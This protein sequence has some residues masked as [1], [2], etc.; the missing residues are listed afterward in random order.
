[1]FAELSITSNFTFLTGVSHPEEYATR[2]TAMGLAGFAIADDNSVAGIVR[3]HAALRDIARVVAERQALEARDGPIGPPAPDPQPPAWA[4]VPRF[5]PAA[6]L[7]LAEGV[8]LTALPRNRAGWGR[9]CRLISTGRLRV[10]KGACHLTVADVI[11]QAADMVLL[12]HPPPAQG[13]TRGAGEWRTQALRLTRR[14]G[15]DMYLLMAPHYD[16]RDA[17]RFDRLATLAEELDLPTVASGLP[18]MHHA[19]RR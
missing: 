7:V 2:A 12:L 4:H 13:G 16:G 6:R 8:T 10:E 11:A 14:L 9:L 18:M 3:A 5:L 1:M 19:R 15:G 17:A